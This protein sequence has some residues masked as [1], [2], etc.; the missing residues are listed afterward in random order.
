MAILPNNILGPEKIVPANH[1]WYCFNVLTEGT[2]SPED[3]EQWLQYIK[4]NRLKHYPCIF[5]NAKGRK[6]CRCN[7]T[8]Q[9]LTL[10]KLGELK[11]RVYK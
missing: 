11:V 1:Y 4:S 5:V 10:Y 7:Y 8:E 2:S 9:F 6:K 3:E